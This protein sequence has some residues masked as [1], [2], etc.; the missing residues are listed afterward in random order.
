MTRLASYVTGFVLSLVLT[1]LPL[2]LVWMHVG[3]QY[4]FLDKGVLYTACVV[5]ALLQLGVQLH[6]FLHM[7]E[8]REPRW[9]LLALSLALVVS[10]IVVG[11]TLWIMNNLSHHLPSFEQA[12]AVPFVEGQ[13]TPQHSN[14]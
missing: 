13:I 12:K 3:S 14:D 8:E 6:F 4:A 10:V 7:G 9:N 11:G 2:A 5:F 1:A